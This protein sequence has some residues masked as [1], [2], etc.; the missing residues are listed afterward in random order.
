MKKHLLLA[1]GLVMTLTASAKWGNSVDKPTELFPAGTNSYATEVR[2]GPDGTVWA[3]IY[4]P[5]LK[6]AEDEYDT[7]NVV[8]E[9]RLQYWNK[10]GNPTFPEEGILLCDYNNMSYTVVNKYLLVDHEGNAIISVADCRNSSDKQRS[11]TAYK[12][13]PDGKMLWGEDGVALTDPLKPAD[14]TACM[15]IVELEDHS[16]VFAWME[17]TGTEAGIHLQRLSNDGKPQW[18]DAKT[19]I[20]DDVAENPIMVNGGENTAILL[21][22]RGSSA[23]LFA[24]KIDFEGENVW[25]KDV[26]IYRGG[27]GSMPTHLYFTCTPSNDGGL[28][29]TW[30]DDRNSTNLE[31]PY[32]SYI[33]SDGKLGFAGMSDEGDVKLAYNQLRNFCPN[34]VEAA[35]G[36]C[37]YVVWRATTG[38]QANQAILMQKVSKEGELMWEDEA[39]YISPLED[40]SKSYTSIQA[41]GESDAVAFFEV[42][43]TYSD[44]ECYA[45]RFNKDGEF[46]WGNGDPLR[47]S[48]PGMAA[49]LE[50]YMMPGQNA[51]LCTW[52]KA[53]SSADADDNLYY[54]IRLNENGTFGLPGDT[55]V[56][57]LEAD[58]ASISFDGKCLRAAV[59]D[60]TMVNV[61]AADGMKVAECV[62]NAGCASVELPAGL[63]IAN[64][65]GK[66]VKFAVK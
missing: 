33:T 58:G 21:Y 36:S 1:A 37:F 35:D 41:A 59:A 46:V 23:N 29:V 27:W 16:Y 42:Y 38:N 47:I 10:E 43:N 66:A 25:G 15:N 48:V 45:T 54:M 63:Y 6:N 50:S 22:T 9:Y 7:K 14:F 62:M 32:L 44:Q 61:Y 26:R 31:S 64:A 60:G 40:A 4:H 11:Y 8:Y 20:T 56:K 57:G 24:R 30:F 3:M 39:R 34:A 2:P 52:D 13:S 28:L 17:G 12:V 18:D 5:N 49:N 65:N 19:A 55:S 51:Y 53:D